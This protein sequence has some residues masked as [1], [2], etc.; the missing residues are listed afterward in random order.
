MT[1]TY[2][3]EGKIRELAE[4]ARMGS[5]KGW[6]YLFQGELEI[7]SPFAVVPDGCS[8]ESSDYSIF[9]LREFV[10]SAG[11]CPDGWETGSTAKKSL[12]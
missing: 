6:T 7:P 9:P 12:E 8:K 10:V 2:S 5:P 3:Q 11:T 4:P 1:I